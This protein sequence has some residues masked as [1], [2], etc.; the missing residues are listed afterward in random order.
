METK[1]ERKKKSKHVPNVPF[2]YSVKSNFSLA[3]HEPFQTP[4]GCFPVSKTGQKV[5][6]ISDNFCERGQGESSYLECTLSY[7]DRRIQTVQGIA[8]NSMC[9]E[10]KEIVKVSEGILRRRGSIPLE[11]LLCRAP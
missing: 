5:F 1:G 8:R 9:W 4:V 2:F 10:N 11:V 6:N 3:A 7:E